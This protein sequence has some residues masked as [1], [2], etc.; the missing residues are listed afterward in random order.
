M[1]RSPSHGYA[2][3]AGALLLLSVTLFAFMSVR[4][5][6]LDAFSALAQEKIAVAERRYAQARLF[7]RAHAETSA[8]R[9]RAFSLIVAEEEV[10]TF[11][12]TIEDRARE[13]DVVLEIGGVELG[14]GPARS[15]L[16]V[17]A[18]FKG[19]FSEAYRFLALL[20]TLPY[21]SSVESLSLQKNKEGGW[22]GYALV[23]VVSD[24]EPRPQ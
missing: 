20:E 17:S 14:S 5:R 15:S 9:A 11:I 24:I 8:S 13:A 6:S 21:A 1:K 2:G 18:R 23:S 22:D 3:A 4:L 16:T 7:V 19:T 12:E 10:G